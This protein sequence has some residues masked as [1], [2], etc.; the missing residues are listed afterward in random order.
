ML[1]VA[2]IVSSGAVRDV[3]TV[4]LGILTGVL[5]GAFGVGGA[6]ISTPGIRLLGASAFLAVGTTLPSIIPGA[7]FGTARYAR[8]GLVSWPTVAATAPAGVAGAVVGSLASRVVPGDG[9]LLMVL[10]AA[11]LAM[12]SYRLARSAPDRR[13]SRAERRPDREAPG[14][15]A[16]AGVGAAAGLLSGLLGVGGG[17]ILVPGFSQVLRLPLK[18][19]IASSLAC[20]G[21]FAVPGTITHGLIG[22]VDWRMALLLAVAVVPGARLGAGLAIAADDARLRLVVALV[23]GVTAVIY[24]G[25]E[26]AVL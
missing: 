13:A 5:S 16:A 10:T 21:I 23:L 17:I 12:A 14:A 15:L 3:L 8:E 26:V 11:L 22:N 18:T 25:S 4:G 6:I 7:V 2:T 19:A 20:V 24:G 1:G 9:H